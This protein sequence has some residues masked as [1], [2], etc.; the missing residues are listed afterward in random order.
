[1]PELP[2]PEVKVE[3]AAPEVHVTNEIDLPSEII[4][5]KRVIRRRGVIEGIEGK[6]KLK[7]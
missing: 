3:V 1:M 6:T 2:T 7:K 4:E 5:T